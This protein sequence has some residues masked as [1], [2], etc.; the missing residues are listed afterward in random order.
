MEGSTILPYLV[1]LYGRSHSICL[2]LE[3]SALKDN[4][5]A[6]RLVKAMVLLSDKEKFIQICEDTT[7]CSHALVK[8]YYKVFVFILHSKVLATLL[9]L[10][11]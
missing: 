11:L 9:V 3:S 4:F 2:D 8:T 7:L 1:E 10:A 5:F 6:Y